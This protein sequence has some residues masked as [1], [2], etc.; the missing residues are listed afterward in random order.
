VAPRW[1][2]AGPWV[3]PAWGALAAYCAVTAPPI[4]YDYGGSVVIVNDIVYDSG[5]QVATVEQY[6][7]QAEALADTGRQAMPDANVEWQP[8][9]VFGLIQGDEKTAQHIFQLAIDK[10]GVVRGN[11]YDAVADNTL[12]VFGSLDPKTQRVAWS[13]GEKKNIVF[14]TGLNN[15]TQQQTGVLVHYG[16]ERTQ[17]ME[18]VR[19]EQPAPG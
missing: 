2:V 18:L 12:P 3:V 16:K 19:L 6:A 15:L 10:S 11:Y 9:G 17:Q 8:L 14:E 13:I 1:R 7:Q 5:Q 4:F